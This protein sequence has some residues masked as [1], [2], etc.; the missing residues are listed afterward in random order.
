[1]QN[2][3]GETVQLERE[4]QRD[5]GRPCA[6]VVISPDGIDRC[7][8][9]QLLQNF[10]PA[11]VACMDDVLNTSQRTDGLRPK[12]SVGVR[13]DAYGF[14]R[15]ARWPAAASATVEAHDLSFAERA[16]IHIEAHQCSGGV[17]GYVELWHFQGV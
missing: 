13:D 7:D 12:Q 16:R 3:D 15:A 4:M 2:V 8:R 5:R 11:D 14:Q 10:G 6:C 9:A 1:V 17:R